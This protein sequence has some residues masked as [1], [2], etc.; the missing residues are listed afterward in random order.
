M[1]YPVLHSLEQLPLEKE[2][3]T[4]NLSYFLRCFLDYIY[5]FLFV[6]SECLKIMKRNS[7]ILS[8]HV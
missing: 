6:T 3:Q 7:F 8:D 5:I 4:T 2:K 1:T